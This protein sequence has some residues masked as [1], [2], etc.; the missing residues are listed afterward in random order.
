MYNGEENTKPLTT[1]G[2]TTSADGKKLYGDAN[3][4]GNIDISDVV[5]VMCRSASPKNNALSSEGEDQADVYSRGDGINAGDAV[6]IQRY[7]TKL[8]TEFNI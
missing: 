4:D 8:I 1:K 7:L 2:Q 6:E 3:N 5:A